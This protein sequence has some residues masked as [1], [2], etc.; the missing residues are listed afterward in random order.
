MNDYREFP[1]K[2]CKTSIS[3]HIMKI[4]SDSFDLS[5]I[6]SPSLAR[7]VPAEKV[8]REKDLEKAAIE[9]QMAPNSKKS[10]KR[11]IFSRGK[12]EKD[13]DSM[14][15][16]LSDLSNDAKSFAGSKEAQSQTYALL[17]F[18]QDGFKLIP[19]DKRY[20]FIPRMKRQKL[21]TEEAEE[22]IGMFMHKPVDRWSMRSQKEVIDSN[23][24]EKKEKKKKKIKDTEELDYDEEFADDEEVDFGIEDREEAR[25]ASQRQY[26]RAGKHALYGEDDYDFEDEEKKVTRM[27]KALTKSLTKIEKND[28]YDG[29]FEESN[30]YIS[31]C[32]FSI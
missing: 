28:M 32:S 21:T 26:G 19:V 16:I 5:S 4:H 17:V 14:P 20:K 18:S 22:K 27:E 1:L 29:L 2:V 12:E 10:F 6:E 11:K 9:A 13:P 30:P 8:L 25:E 3:H 24:K 15:W 23:K 7:Q 31:V